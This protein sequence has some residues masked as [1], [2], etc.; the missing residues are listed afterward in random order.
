MK[1][2][3]NQTLLKYARDTGKL[4]SIRARL[5]RNT[6][7]IFD[8]SLPNYLWAQKYLGDTYEKVILAPKGIEALGESKDNQFTVLGGWC[9]I[10]TKCLRDM[11]KGILTNPISGKQIQIKS[12]SQV[13]YWIENAVAADQIIETIGIYNGTNYVAISEESLWT[14]KIINTLELYLNR[15]LNDLEKQQI[16]E[17]VI[18]AEKKRYKITKKYIEYVLKK[19]ANLTRI[20]DTDI[21]DKLV[22]GRDELFERMGTTIDDL[23]EPMITRILK[24]PDT[25][26]QIGTKTKEDLLN[27]IN[28]SSLVWFMY[29]GS[30]FDILRKKKYVTTQKGI[31][32]EPWSHAVSNESE[33]KFNSIFFTH[34]NS[35]LH[36]NGINEDIAYIT[37]DEACTFNWK[38]SKGYLP[39]SEVPNIN[40]YESLID[41]L[42]TNSTISDLNLAKNISFMYGVNYLPY[43]NCKKALLDMVYIADEFHHKKKNLKKW[44]KDNQIKREKIQLLKSEYS[45]TIKNL[46]LTVN[47]ELKNMFITIFS[48]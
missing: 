31:I 26:L 8:G 3:N 48:A 7:R 25:E 5:S 6:G 20:I 47:K 9:A 33:A 46:A 16:L 37:I 15:R 42:Q 34:N 39:L 11:G 21:Y 24:K 18:I 29:T 44:N 14:K 32:I 40:N 12:I 41:A 35:Y 4:N 19:T 30:Y 22:E 23:I 10:R 45:S 13:A 43:G 17:A 38:P 27:Y 1:Q 2:N 36:P 28:S